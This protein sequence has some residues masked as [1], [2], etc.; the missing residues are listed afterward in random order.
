MCETACS[1]QRIVRTRRVCP[2][3]C[4]RPATTVTSLSR[5]PE[6]SAVTRDT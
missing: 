5:D 6:L 2:R 4:P 3:Q 1:V